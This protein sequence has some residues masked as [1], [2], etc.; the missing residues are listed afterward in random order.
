MLWEFVHLQGKGNTGS[1]FSFPLPL[2]PWILLLE[3]FWTCN[4]IWCLTYVEC[5]CKNMG[6]TFKETKFSLVLGAFVLGGLFQG[7]WGLFVCLFLSVCLGFF[8]VSFFLFCLGLGFFCWI[9]L[10]V[11]DRYYSPSDVSVHVQIKIKSSHLTSLKYSHWKTAVVLG[12]SFFPQGYW[13]L[14]GHYLQAWL[15]LFSHL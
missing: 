14:T 1:C 12:K 5:G 15:F 8:C 2:P 6:R 11:E 3:Q 4:E 13:K 10:V 7:V 9:S